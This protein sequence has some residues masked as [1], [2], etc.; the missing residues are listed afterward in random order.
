MIQGRFAFPTSVVMGAG[1][2]GELGA[3]LTELGVKRPLLVTDPGLLPTP[4]FAAV[5]QAAGKDCAVY[6]GVQ[7]NPVEADVDGAVAAF[8]EHGCDGVVGV[9]GG[10]ALDVA[11]ILR[12]RVALPG[13]ALADFY[14]VKDWPALAPFVAVPT[15]AGTGSEVGRSS[16]VTV[17]GRKQVYFHP[18]LL[19]ARVFLDPELTVSLPPKL[20]AA[21]GMDAL[22]HC[23]ESFASPVYHPLCDGIALE[24]A[25]L[26]NEFLPRA[27][28]DGGD[29]EARGQ[30]LV[31]AAMGGIAFQKDLG[32]VHS[33]AH[34]LSA[35]HHMHHGLANALCLVAVM[36]LNAQRKPGLYRRLAH[37]LGLA[38]DN[39]AAV[40]ARV[41]ELLAQCGIQPGLRA[42][43]V[44][45][46]SIEA[47]SAAAV[48]D[49]CHQTNPVPVTKGD[50]ADLY[51]RCL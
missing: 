36:E 18:S 49:S 28:R 50:F 32:A 14:A 22:T 11:K 48:E 39:D 1:C 34:P 45:E 40:I 16:V 25:R 51:R 46:E 8:R 4:A 10:S 43:G 27:V 20:T 12:A 31:A 5:Q 13:V 23:I 24:G 19:A 30:M 21:T 3:T 41:K 7:G 2:I 15:T 6:S 35:L 42:H 33:M 47:L 44:T 9:G 29:L 37:A 38:D 26:V 17:G